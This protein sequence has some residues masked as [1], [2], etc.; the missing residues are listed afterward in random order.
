MYWKKKISPVTPSKNLKNPSKNLS[1]IYNNPSN[2]VRQNYVRQTHIRHIHTEHIRHIH[3]KI[4]KIPRL[5][6]LVPSIQQHHWLSQLERTEHEFPIKYITSNKQLLFRQT[7]RHEPRPQPKLIHHGPTVIRLV[8]QPVLHQLFV[9]HDG[10]S[11]RWVAL[12]NY[13]RK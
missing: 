8:I 5:Y 3:M 1:V 10:L 2:L 13:T 6:K 4:F 11:E 12:V 9:L 7:T